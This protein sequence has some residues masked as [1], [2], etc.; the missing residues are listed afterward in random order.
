MITALRVLLFASVVFASSE[1]FAFSEGYTS[2]W[3]GKSGYL[4]HF[5]ALNSFEDESAFVLI[6]GDRR[7]W[8]WNGEN[9]LQY[10]DLV[11]GSPLKWTE[12]LSNDLDLSGYHQWLT[13]SNGIGPEFLGLSVTDIVTDV[14]DGLGWWI[15]AFV[16]VGFAALLVGYGL[17]AFRNTA[18]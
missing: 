16:L 9:L 12:V 1:A 6:G 18:G 14:A 7:E 15:G 4:V 11:P 8:Y 10:S 2:D 17:K 13:F 5:G 3:F